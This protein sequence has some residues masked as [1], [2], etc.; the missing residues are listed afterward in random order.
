MSAKG[1]GDDDEILGAE[2]TKGVSGFARV[3]PDL[4]KISQVR[5]GT[6]EPMNAFTPLTKF[7]THIRSQSSRVS[8]DR[9]TFS[10]LLRTSGPTI[11]CTKVVAGRAVPDNPISE[12][13]TPVRYGTQELMNA[14][15][16]LTNF[17][18]RSDPFCE[19]AGNY[20]IIQTDA[21]ELSVL[22]RIDRTCWM[23]AQGGPHIEVAPGNVTR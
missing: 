11:V 9:S 3:G 16:P 5:Y 15:T 7:W 8:K 22:A 21:G 4:K 20:G 14:F 19:V 6:Q 18:S 1:A 13:G 10:H 17:R 23:G 12:Q 2:N